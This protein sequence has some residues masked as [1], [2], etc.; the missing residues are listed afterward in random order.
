MKENFSG[1]YV[2][3]GNFTQKKCKVKPCLA[4]DISVSVLYTPEPEI[5]NILK[6]SAK[7]SERTEVCIGNKKKTNKK[8]VDC[9]RYSAIF[10]KK[11]L[12]SSSDI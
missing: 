9:T 11:E 7:S 5:K 1:K 6:E 2:L 10:I 3:N 12:A 8:P 4:T